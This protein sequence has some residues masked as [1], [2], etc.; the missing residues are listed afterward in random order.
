MQEALA[1]LSISY[2]IN[3]NY[4]IRF[5]E[6]NPDKHVFILMEQHLDI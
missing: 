4:Q 5:V 6:L 3:V 2:N 1:K